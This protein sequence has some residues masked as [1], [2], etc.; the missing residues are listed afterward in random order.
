M[1][2]RRILVL[3]DGMHTAELLAEANDVL[4]LRDAEVVLVYVRGRTARHGLDLVRRRPGGAPMPAHRERSIAEAE[5]VRGEEALAEAE[6]LAV[7]LADSVRTLL[8]DGEAGREVVELARRERADV[9][10]LRAG[11]RGPLGPA[12]RFIADHAS[13]T[14]LLVRGGR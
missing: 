6:R 5:Q 10:A 11:A 8:V 7:P 9:V 2:T 4:R 13:C 12:S 14:V 3:I 1:A